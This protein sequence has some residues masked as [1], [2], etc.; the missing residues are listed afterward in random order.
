MFLCAKG[1]I[2][3][4]FNNKSEISVQWAAH[5]CGRRH[6]SPET[7]RIANNKWKNISDLLPVGAADLVA[8]AVQGVCVAETV[9]EEVKLNTLDN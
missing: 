7:K 6:K 3:Y 4:F 5:C 9:S 2:K 8:L 1:K